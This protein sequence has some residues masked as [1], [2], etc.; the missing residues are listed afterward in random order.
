MNVMNKF[1]Q[2]KKLMIKVIAGVI[3]IAVAFAFYLM[4]SNDSDGDLV[5]SDFSS[6]ET[7]IQTETTKSAVEET[8]MIIVDVSGAVVNPCVAELPDGS[9]VYEAVEKAGGF[10]PEAE[11]N[12]INQAEILTDGQKVYIPTKKE[13]AGE[14]VNKNTQTTQNSTSS[15][16]PVYSTGSGQ[17]GKINI[18]T[19]DSTGLQELT[20]VGPSTAEKIIN[21][22]NENGKFKTIE[23]LKNVSGIGD[24][25]FEKLKDKITV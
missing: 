8:V 23:D 11:T 15:Y 17:S 5:L 24:K 25:T 19:A 1:T 9:R 22:R 6:E 7:P 18:N 3:F 4:K 20:G 13:V 14:T 2:N 12:V 21:Y 16:A 10:T